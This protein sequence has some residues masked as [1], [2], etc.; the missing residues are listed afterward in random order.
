N[1]SGR[2]I[3]WTDTDRIRSICTGTSASCAPMAQALYTADGTRTHNKVTQGTTS[4][5]TL[6]V[7]QY[8]TVRNGTL[9]TKHVYLGDARIAS[10]VESNATTNNTYF[11]HSDN[12]QSAQ[13]VTANGQLPVQHL[14]YYPSG[15]IWRESTDTAAG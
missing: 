9:P 8:L 13:Y 1:G 4:F 15:D 2:N 5:E 14:E 7:N 10:K 3:T 6:Y 12:I 11:Y